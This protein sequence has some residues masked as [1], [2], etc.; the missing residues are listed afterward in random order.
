MAPELMP[1][2]DDLRDMMRELDQSRHAGEDATAQ[3]H[4]EKLR[5]VLQDVLSGDEIIVLSN[6]E[7]YSH[8]YTPQGIRV[9]RPASG[10]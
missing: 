6:R 9:K 10:L 7:P 1:V 5:S 2:L 3:W 8:V 4:A